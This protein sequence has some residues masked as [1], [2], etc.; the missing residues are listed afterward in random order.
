MAADTISIFATLPILEI[1]I[2][3]AAAVLID[4]PIVRAALLQAAM[5][6]LGERNWYLP[7]SL[8]TRDR[9]S[10]RHRQQPG[11]R[12]HSHGD[13]RGRDTRSGPLRRDV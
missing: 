5:R 1:G 6:L 4:A 8:A 10:R 2:G 7:A 11:Q 12:H 13:R 3:L 9:A